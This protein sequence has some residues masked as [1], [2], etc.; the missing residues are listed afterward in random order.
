LLAQFPER[1]IP[2]SVRLGCP[3]SADTLVISRHSTTHNHPSSK[4]RMEICS[5]HLPMSSNLI[6]GCSK[7]GKNCAA[8]RTIAYGQ[9]DAAPSGSHQLL[10]RF[11][12]KA[13]K[14]YSSNFS[15]KTM[16]PDEAGPS[17]PTEC[18]RGHH[19]R[20]NSR[21]AGSGSTIHRAALE[22]NNSALEDHSDLI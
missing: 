20:G 10:K 7:V 14:E 21:I 8:D 9:C 15:V 5:L 16:R 1:K 6:C 12:C 3:E 2:G 22:A 18:L 4:K 19:H 17:S 13:G 11:S